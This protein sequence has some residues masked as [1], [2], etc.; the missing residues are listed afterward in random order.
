MKKTID[1]IIPV[2]NGLPYVLTTL[3]SVMNQTLKP[4][5]ILVV[6][7]GSTDKTR[8]ALE[9]VQKNNPHSNIDII[10]KKNGGHSSATNE[11]IRQSTAD[12]I[13]LVDADDTWEPTKLEKQ[14][15]VFETS[16]I[17][18]LG[19]VYTNFDSI[20]QNDKVINFPTFTMDLKARGNLFHEL[21]K[22]GNLIAGSNSAV[23]VRKECFQKAGFFDEFL[24]CGEDWDMWI[25]TSQSFAYD[26]VPEILVHIRRHPQNLSN[27]PMIHLKS[28]LYILQKWVDKLHELG[29]YTL[30]ADHLSV[31]TL[32]NLKEL[33]FKSEHAILRGYVQ[34]LTRGFPF[35]RL[36]IC[37]GVIRK[38]RKKTFKILGS[39]M[40]E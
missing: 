23:L 40:L 24:R 12:F 28:N 9:E 16:E 26:Y 5:R 37:W 4:D 6:N 39:R 17:P 22:R 3:R 13:A 38:F 11:G 33:F 25:R 18:N 27:V 36:M 8:E 29:G 2:Y 21:L 14:M 1:V 19:I 10:N 15:K 31:S 7:D 32:P 20:D 34:K 35:P 30:I